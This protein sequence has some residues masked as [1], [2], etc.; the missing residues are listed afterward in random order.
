VE[1]LEVE[2]FNSFKVSAAVVKSM[3]EKAIKVR[4]FI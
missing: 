4:L 2:P 3:K 1:Q